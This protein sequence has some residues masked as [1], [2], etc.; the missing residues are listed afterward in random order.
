MTQ[1]TLETE[2]NKIKRTKHKTIIKQKA[3]QFLPLKVEFMFMFSYNLFNQVL[4]YLI[5]IEDLKSMCTSRG[6]S[7]S[8]L[9]HAI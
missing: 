2:K 6:T 9:T 3:N 5:L 4:S 1:G 7:F 8:Y